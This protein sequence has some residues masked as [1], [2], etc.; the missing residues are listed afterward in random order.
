MANRRP[1][2]EGRKTNAQDIRITIVTNL[3]PARVAAWLLAATRVPDADAI[4]GDLWEELH[5][6]VA[7]KRGLVMGRLWYVQ[8][9]LRSL[10]PLFFRSWQRA[11]IARASAAMIAAAAAAAVPAACLLSLRAFV[12]SQVPLKTT[13]EL[14][15]AFT[16]LL[17]VVLGASGIAGFAVGGRLLH[18]H[19]PR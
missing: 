19:D 18:S 10:A 17:L 11:S 2:R 4:I 13:P 7:P 6:H 9:V 5:D 14:S 3:C 16:L 8:Q 12:L 15:A 1:E